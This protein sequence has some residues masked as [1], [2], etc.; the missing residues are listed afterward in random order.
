M[1]TVKWDSHAGD[2]QR[3]FQAGINEYN[4]GLL[5][6]LMEKQMLRPGC[7]VLDVGCG[8][9]KYGTYFAALGCDVTLTDISGQMLRRAE[10]NMRPFSTPWRTLQCDFNTVSPD[11][12]A[13][14]GGFDLAVS[15]MSPAIH[16]LET[17]Q[18][19]SAMTHG[20][21]FITNFVSWRQPLRD[22]FY[23]ALGFDPAASMAGGR[24][25]MDTLVR[26]VSAAG[27]QPQ[28]RYVPYDWLDIRSPREAAAYLIRRHGAMD[29]QDTA[30]LARAETVA[31]GLCNARGEFEDAVYTQVA[32]L[33]WRS[34]T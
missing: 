3:V 2:Y 26:A 13:F 23:T 33:Y 11:E 31:A 19:L 24:D 1:D 27:F 21:C 20:W 5:D 12:A 7:R 8:V 29:E 9:G 4:R 22:R 10:E 14:A 16:D 25:T 6:F 18:K 15:T 34:N 28:L 17:V 32:W 30:L